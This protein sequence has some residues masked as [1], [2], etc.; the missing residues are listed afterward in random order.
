MH[1][2]VEQRLAGKALAREHE[3]DCDPG[4]QARG[5]TRERY[6]EAEE[7]DAGFVA[8]HGN[9]NPWCSK[10]ARASGEAR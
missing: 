1:E 3:R 9:R 10:I 4:R 8:A 2:R 6:L 7:Q 5:E